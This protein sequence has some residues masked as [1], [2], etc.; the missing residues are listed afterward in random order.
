MKYKEFYVMET[1]EMTLN[2]IVKKGIELGYKLVS[3]D[4]SYDAVR[5]F[6]DGDFSSCRSSRDPA[7]F[8]D[9]DSFLELQAPDV[10]TS[11]WW[12]KFVFHNHAGEK[13]VF[14]AQLTKDEIDQVNSIFRKA[15][16]R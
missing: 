1:S 8:L 11:E 9:A 12:C 3:I 14:D 5:F 16:K 4:N 2:Q 6:N 7:A 10:I 15:I 13:T